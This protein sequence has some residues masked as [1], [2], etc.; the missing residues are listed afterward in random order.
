MSN[1]V[2]DQNTIQQCFP[3][4]AYFQNCIAIGQLP[5]DINMD[6]FF[7]L[8]HDILLCKTGGRKIIPDLKNPDKKAVILTYENEEMARLSGFRVNKIISRTSFVSYDGNALFLYCKQ[9]DQECDPRSRNLAINGL[10]TT[11]PKDMYLDLLKVFGTIRYFEFCFEGD[12]PKARFEFTR[13][14]SAYAA[15][16]SLQG[17]LSQDALVI[18]EIPLFPVAPISRSVRQNHTA[19]PYDNVN[20]VHSP[21]P[22]FAP[23]DE[24]KERCFML[25]SMNTLNYY[26]PEER[27]ADWS[28]RFS[29]DSEN[30][31]GTIEE[32]SMGAVSFEFSRK[33]MRERGFVKRWCKGMFDSLD[34]VCEENRRLFLQAAKRKILSYYF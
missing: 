2:Q 22:S 15:M 32:C 6:Q 14:S 21:I 17:T 30:V 11:V 29:E 13:A 16:L 3:E 33:R 8:F 34:K 28:P 20:Q 18:L 27:F 31:K 24:V 26:W 19:M 4:Q 23:T 9:L 5:A 10:D 7:C 25:C 12:I 1:P